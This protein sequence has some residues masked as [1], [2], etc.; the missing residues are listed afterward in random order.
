MA[1]W[2]CL[3]NEFCLL[4]GLTSCKDIMKKS[5]LIKL[6]LLVSTFLTFAFEIGQLLGKF[7]NPLVHMKL[8]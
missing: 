4:K 5:F 3:A 8:T 7:Q 6:S 2:L 1:G